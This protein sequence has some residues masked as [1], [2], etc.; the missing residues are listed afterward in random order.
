MRT[1]RKH[2]GGAEGQIILGVRVPPIGGAA[3]ALLSSWRSAFPDVSLKIMDGNERDIALGLAERRLDVALVGGHTIWPHVAACPLF[4]EKLIVV[5]PGQHRLVGQVSV[6]WEDVSRETIL[7]QGWPENQTQRE[8]YATLV[9]NAAHFEVHQASKQTILALVRAGFGVTLAT[10]S[11]VEGQ[12][13]GIEFRPVEE[14][15]AWLEFDLVWLPESENPV[16]G[17]F[18]AFMRD[19]SRARGFV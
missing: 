12:A 7:V 15:N 6:S 5:I 19:E 16:A 11:Q 18:V 9:S 1:S 13:P 17:R 4:R 2:A 8:Y 14:P 10:E 3:Q